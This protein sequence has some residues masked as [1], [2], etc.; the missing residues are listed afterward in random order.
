MSNLTITDGDATY[1]NAV[2]LIYDSVVWAITNAGY[3]NM[4]IVIGEIGWPTDGYPHAN[5]KNAE[6]F[7]KGLLKFIASKQGTPLRPG[8]IEAYLHS[9]SDENKFLTTF[10]AYQRHWGIYESNGNPKYK[11]DFSSQDRD[12]YPFQAK[13]VVS[14]PHR[15]CVFNGDTSNLALVRKNYKLACEVTDCT[16]LEEGS[17]CGGLSEESKFL[18]LSMDV[19]KGKSKK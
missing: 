13:G 15:W 16:T 19:T 4:K 12:E 17:S 2:E 6:R 3:P 9:L 8:P 11:I 14:M 5:I 1:T 10:G 7:N 18:M